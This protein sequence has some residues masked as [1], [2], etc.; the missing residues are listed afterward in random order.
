[1]TLFHLVPAA[2]WRLTEGR[3][4]YE[5]DSLATEGF[6][7]LS[8]AGQVAGTAARFFAGVPDLLLLEV[9]IP[10]DDPR[11][12]WEPSDG[13]RGVEEFPHYHGVLPLAYV[14]GRSRWRSGA[15]PLGPES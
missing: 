8:T 14:V 15:E 9:E 2:R 10:E 5:P 6:V 7:H 12:R 4:A 1:M 13:P 11:L 3:P